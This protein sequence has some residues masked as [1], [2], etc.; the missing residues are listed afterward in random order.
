M[1][2]IIVLHKQLTELLMYGF[3]LKLKWLRLYVDRNVS[4]VSIQGYDAMT[5]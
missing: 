1:I 4:D 2:L 5:Q 3:N